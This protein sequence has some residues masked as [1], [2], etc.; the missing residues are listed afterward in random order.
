MWLEECVRCLWLVFIDYYGHVL[1]YLDW[2]FGIEQERKL[3][4]RHRD[5]Q[6][7]HKQHY[8]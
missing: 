4:H 1:A 6:W 8:R 3:I 2:F 5:E 7:Q